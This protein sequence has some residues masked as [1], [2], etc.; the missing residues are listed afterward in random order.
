MKIKTIF[1][2]AAAWLLALPAAADDVTFTDNNGIRYLITSSE[3]YTAQVIRFSTDN[4]SG[5]IVIPEYAWYNNDYYKVTSIKGGDSMPET[6]EENKAYG[7]FRDNINITSITIPSGVEEIEYSAF[8]NCTGLK[9]VYNNGIMADINGWTFCGCTSLKYCRIP[10][11]VT[12]FGESAF[13]GCT[14]LTELT[15]PSSV[16]LGQYAFK[17]CSKLASIY[18]CGTDLTLTPESDQWHIFENADNLVIYTKSSALETIKGVLDGKADW[19]KEKATADI[20]FTPSKDIVT[21]ARDFDVDFSEASELMVRYASS[22]SGGTLALAS[23]SSAPAG[24]GLLIKGTAGN[25]YTLRIAEESPSSVG[26]N[27]LVGVVAPQS[28]AQ[29][30]GGY[31]NFVLTDGVFK[32]VPE[33]G[34]STMPAGKAYLQLNLSSTSHEISFSFDEVVTGLEEVSTPK[35]EL[36]RTVYDLQ[37]RQITSDNL[38]KGLYI[39]NG[40]KVVIR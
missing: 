28:L 11:T 27:L 26:D 34:I 39:I 25:S 14:A 17:N 7:A 1:L 33:A 18:Y 8:Y 31:T 15:I 3:K 32:K 38:S 24:T 5:D 40:K 6:P 12:T 37:G 23:V 20:P 30:D 36:R 21:F 13:E 2:C 29:T 10:S 9:Y 16:S 19:I 22:Y 4:Y 35:E